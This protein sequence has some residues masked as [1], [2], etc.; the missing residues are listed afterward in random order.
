MALQMSLI[1]QRFNTG[2]GFAPIQDFTGT[3]NGNGNTI[4]GLY[5]NYA[6]STD[7]GLFHDIQTGGS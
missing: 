6:T 7:V 1:V 4:T 5:E 3:F 2:S